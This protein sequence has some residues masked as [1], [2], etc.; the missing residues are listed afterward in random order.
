MMTVLQPMKQWSPISRLCSSQTAGNRFYVPA[1]GVR[2]IHHRDAV[3]KQT[4]AADFNRV[5][6]RDDKI[7]ADGRAGTI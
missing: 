5:V 2:V 6:R 3:G 7:I 4:V 1:G